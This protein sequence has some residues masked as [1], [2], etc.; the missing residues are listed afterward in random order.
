LTKSATRPSPSGK[1]G[2][3]H[4]HLLTLAERLIDG[5][6]RSVALYLADAEPSPVVTTID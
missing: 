5:D 4:F 1:P 3:Q 2:N 6:R